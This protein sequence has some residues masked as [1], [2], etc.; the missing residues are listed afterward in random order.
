QP[1]LLVALAR[2]HH[3]TIGENIGVHSITDIGQGVI[4]VTSIRLRGCKAP[5]L[6]MPC[7]SSG[8]D[9]IEFIF[10]VSNKERAIAILAK[11]IRDDELRALTS[12]S[13]AGPKQMLFLLLF[14]ERDDAP[15]IASK[16]EL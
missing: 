13:G 16:H 3:P 14:R 7:N 10:E 9:I 12:T 2:I 8:S 6:V 5:D 15:V 4:A 11:Q 1:E